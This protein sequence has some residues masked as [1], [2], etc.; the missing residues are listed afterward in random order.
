MSQTVPFS[1][2]CHRQSS[3]TYI[4]GIG[5]LSIYFIL[6]FCFFFG[7]YLFFLSMVVSNLSRHRWD[8]DF[9]SLRLWRLSW[10]STLH[11]VETL[12]TWWDSHL[13]PRDYCFSIPVKAFDAGQDFR[14]ILPRWAFLNMSIPQLY[15][16]DQNIDTIKAYMYML[17]FSIEQLVYMTIFLCLFVGWY[18][19][20]V[21]SC[22]F[23]RCLL[24]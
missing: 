17:I 5:C 12:S 7:V 9:E 16:L 13:K 11:L 18:V 19:C 23:L 24:L 10:Q 20:V 8:R 4:Q 15:F 14:L 6:P 21:V 1:Y 22:L 3:L 2:L